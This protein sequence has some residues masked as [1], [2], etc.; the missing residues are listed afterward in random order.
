MSW[1]WQGGPSAP[2]GGGAR[3]VPQ[4]TPAFTGVVAQWA[5][6][7]TATAPGGV[8]PERVSGLAARAMTRPSY[9]FP[10]MRPAPFTAIR[11]DL[12]GSTPCAQNGAHSADL[13]INGEMTLTAKCA[14]NRAGMTV[15]LSQVI[16]QSRVNLGTVAEADNCNYALYVSDTGV[17]SYFA[18][19]GAGVAIVFNSALSMDNG[20]AGGLGLWKFVSLRRAASGVVTLGVDGVFQTSGALAL[21]TG[22]TN[23]IMRFGSTLNVERNTG[24][25]SDVSLGNVAIVDAE[26]N[27]VRR[28]AM[29][30]AA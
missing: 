11:C 6:D 18:Q 4:L 25:I 2:G 19:Q 9:F 1:H 21:P 23:T 28:V 10:D 16:A 3:A 27:R 17:L 5:L 13:A 29:A 30:V 14:W 15:G 7:G 12:P 20:G 22:G 24:I 8:L 26:L